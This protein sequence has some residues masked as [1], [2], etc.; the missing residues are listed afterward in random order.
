[1]KQNNND[2]VF[3]K[4]PCVLFQDFTI[5]PDKCMSKNEKYNILIRL[6]LIVSLLLYAFNYDKWRNILF[7]GFLFILLAY[8]LSE[9]KTKK[10]EHFSFPRENKDCLPCKNRIGQTPNIDS[11]NQKYELKLPIQFNHDE[12]AKRSYANAKYELTPLRDTQGFRQIWR[13]EPEQCGY[14]S[15]PPRKKYSLDI[16][17]PEQHNQCNYISRVKIG[18]DAYGDGQQSLLA[19][20]ALAE[21][22]YKDGMIAQRSV[23]DDYTDRFNRERKHNCID[24]KLNAAASGSGY[25][26]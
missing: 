14:Y 1:M 21:Q 24:M 7:Y 13:K 2:A 9:Q 26:V 23:I 11:I 5:L 3:F 10:R 16:H 19:T 18:L 8:V 17:P 15:M 4:D 12:A 20:R 22:S 6:L 25:A